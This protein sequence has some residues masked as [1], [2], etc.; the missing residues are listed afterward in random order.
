MKP[1]APPS[2]YVSVPGVPSN[3]SCFSC[4][5]STKAGKEMHLERGPIPVPPNTFDFMK[6]TNWIELVSLTLEFIQMASFA[7]QR[8]PYA[9]SNKDEDAPTF[10]PTASPSVGITVNSAGD[11]DEIAFWGKDLFE[12]FAQ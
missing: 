3:K 11:D 4:C 1:P 2:M 8:D 12:V 9:S 10:F 6:P 5:W 7:L